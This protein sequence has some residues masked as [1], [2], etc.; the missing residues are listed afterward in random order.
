MT[1][2][3]LKAMREFIC[4]QNPYKLYRIFLFSENVKGAGFRSL[5]VFSLTSFLSFSKNK[6]SFWTV[7]SRIQVCK[8][9][10]LAREEP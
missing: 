8:N 2:A 6:N 4:N 3:I 7:C 1:T 9:S 5:N 10:L